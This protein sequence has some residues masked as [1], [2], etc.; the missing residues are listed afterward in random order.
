MIWKR[1]FRSIDLLALT[2]DK[3]EDSDDEKRPRIIDNYKR[4]LAGGLGAT[5]VPYTFRQSNPDEYNHREEENGDRSEQ[6]TSITFVLYP[7][8]NPLSQASTHACS[9]QDPHLSSSSSGRKYKTSQ[10]GGVCSHKTPKKENEKSY[11]SF[12][13]IL[14]FY[15]KNKQ[16]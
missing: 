5:Q 2:S 6:R 15:N 9:M 12:K 7:I 1:Q 13:L 4:A 11:T 16:F 3:S 14:D 8:S 10:E